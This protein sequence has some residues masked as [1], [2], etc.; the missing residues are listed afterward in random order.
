[1]PKQ[2]FLD[3]LPMPKTRRLI[4]LAIKEHGRLTADELAEML[5]ISAVA[6]R[7]HLETLKNA[8]LVQ[9]EEMPQGVGRPSFVYSLTEEAAHI[10]PRNYEELAHDMLNTIQ[11]LYGQEAVAAIFKKRAQKIS[12]IYR[13]FVNSPSLEGRIEQLVN[14]RQAD[15]YMATWEQTDDGSFIVTELNCPIQHVAE[16]CAQA[17]HEDLRLFSNLLDA[18]VILLNHKLQGDNSCC[19]CIKPKT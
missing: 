14:L 7:R 15:G 2:G 19:Y 5:H 11:E 12:Q 1:M 8:N 18:D 9:Y 6:V 17:C 16:E 3:N 10:F 4:L 13:P